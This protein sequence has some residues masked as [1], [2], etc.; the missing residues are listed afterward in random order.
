MRKHQKKKIQNLLST[1]YEVHDEIKKSVEAETPEQ[2]M[3]LLAQCQEAAIKIG[4]L[5]E[6]TEGEAFITTDLLEQYCEVIYQIY[7]ELNQ[8]QAVSAGRMYKTLRKQLIQVENSVKNDI[9][10]Q[11]EAVF[12]PYKASMWDSFES[13]YLAAK[14]D[15]QCQAYCVPIPYFDRKPDKSM[16]QMHY[17]GQEYP[18]Y[19]EVTDWKTYH[20]EERY[21]DII[22]VQNP[23]DDQNFVT[24]VHPDYYTDRLR[25]YTDLL[26]YLEYGIPMWVQKRSIP[27]DSVPQGWLNADICCTYSRESAR[28]QLFAMKQVKPDLSTEVVALGSA[29]F[30]KVLNLKRED[31]ELPKDWETLIAGRKAVLFNTSIA[32][33]LKDTEVYLE[34]LERTFEI[35]R[36]N[37]DA[38]LWWRPHPLS[39]ATF[40]SMRSNLRE[41]YT[42]IVNQYK[43]GG[44]GIY[45]DSMDPHRAIICTDAYYGDESSLV[46]LY[47]ATG[48]PFTIRKTLGEF[49]GIT[50]DR[51]DFKHILQWRIANMQ[52]AKGANIGD[53][54][55]CIW[56][57]NFYETLD[58]ENFLT[59]FLDYV[60][61][62]EGY[63]EAA[64]YQE[65]QLQLFYD[66]VVNA[67]GTAG[68]HIYEY[69]QKR[70]TG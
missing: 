1:L 27:Y 49:H 68:E 26:V 17:E 7:E 31:F 65:L 52:K 41:K 57:G 25:Q 30:D 55:A 53:W 16:G 36:K 12:F 18:D 42:Y 46:Y 28:N 63:T 20:V 70:V 29:K 67:D 66:F 50:A 62:Q 23:Y 37:N 44:W 32:G 6:E 24:S 21:P 43:S 4:S 40:Q 8:G 58:Y 2:A 3:A 38:V 47:C 22:F 10:V 48:K 11:I 13:V 69:C 15:P 54:N 64:I 59:L 35:F 19:V 14:K 60:V 56:W 33:I 34:R 61:H 51:P 45:D 9:P 39:E 5:I